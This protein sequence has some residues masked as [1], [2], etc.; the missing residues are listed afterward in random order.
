MALC[1]CGA[2]VV[3]PGGD[4]PL[5]PACLIRLALEPNTIDDRPSSEREPPRL[6]GPVGSGP[7]G[8]V[9]LAY[10]PYDEPPIVTIKLVNAE[11]EQLIDAERFCAHV[12]T[13]AERLASIQSAGL[14]AFLEPGVTADGR[15]YVIAPYVPGSSV[16]DYITSR[17][18][19]PSERVAVARRLCALVAELH[20]HGIVHGSIKS[21]NIIVAESPNGPLPTLL[22]VGIVPAVEQS[23]GIA[24]GPGRQNDLSDGLHRDLRSLCEVL[25]QLLGE[26]L[27]PDMRGADSAAALAALLAP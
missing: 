12:R 7:H 17:R 13:L 5:C 26:P 8:L 4:T 23:R 24:S 27:A 10:R 22:D 6:L 14:P 16:N 25:I 18:R 19:P 1:A 15:P 21:P 2:E 20:R 11:S 9:Y 3:R